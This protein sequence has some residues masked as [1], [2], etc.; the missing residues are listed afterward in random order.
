MTKKNTLED[1][2]YKIKLLERKIKFW[3]EKKN[4]AIY[5]IEKNQNRIKDLDLKNEWFFKK[6]IEYKIKLL[7]QKNKFWNDKMNL[8]LY[9]IEKYDNEISKLKD[10]GLKIDEYEKSDQAKADKNKIWIKQTKAKVIK[11]LKKSCEVIC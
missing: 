6:D 11:E 5:Y 2:N 8:S 4:L 10:L 3:I 9:Y 7:E 1:I